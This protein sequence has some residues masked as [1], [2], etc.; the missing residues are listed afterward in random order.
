MRASTTEEAKLR[1]QEGY[2]L[3][4]QVRA[5]CQDG[6]ENRLERQRLYHRVGLIELR[7]NMLRGVSNDVE[8]A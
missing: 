2:R 6:A 4:R 1:P 8:V 5:G 3:A 7:P